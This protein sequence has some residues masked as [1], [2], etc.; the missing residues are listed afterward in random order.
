M[1]VGFSCVVFFIIICNVKYLLHVPR[2]LGQ[3]KVGL[4]VGNDVDGTFW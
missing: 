1:S 4:E 2:V 3:S